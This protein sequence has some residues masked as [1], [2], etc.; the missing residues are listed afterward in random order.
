MSQ[1]SIELVGPMSRV[2]GLRHLT[3][4]LGDPATLAEL[5][6]AIRRTAP[7]LEGSLIKAE[8]DRL[9]GHYTFNV[10]G[11][12]HMDEYDTA[13]HPGDRVL[14]VSLAMGG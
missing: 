2:A 7:E 14:I 5:V 13:V 10:N 8:Q 3:V 12:F 6:A 4:E 1:Y 11:R 9:V